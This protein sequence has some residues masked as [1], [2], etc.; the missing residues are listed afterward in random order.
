MTLRVVAVGECMLEL[1]HVND[2]S[3]TLSVAGD[4]FNTAVHLWR[5]LRPRADV[6]YATALGSGWY[7]DFIRNRI[8][9]EGLKP[10]LVETQGAP[11]AYFIRTDDTGE[12]SFS[13]HRSESAA[14]R[15]FDGSGDTTL[16]ESIDGADL[17]HFSAITLQ[18]L[19][20]EA[21]QRFFAVLGAARE[22]G[23]RISFDTNYRPIGWP[24]QHNARRVI[25]EF[26]E[27]ANIVLPSLD[28]ERALG[29]T[30]VGEVVDRY[31]AIGADEV[32]VKDGISPTTLATARGTRTIDVPHANT[33]VDTTGAGDAF[34]AGYLAYRLMGRPP[35][36]AV[37]A[38]HG[39]A[40][41]VVAHP[42][43]IGGRTTHPP[44]CKE[45]HDN[46]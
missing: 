10:V 13:Y 25:D 16:E 39:L 17:V 33:A 14:R 20:A 4:T 36:S 8:Q 41:R 26:A 5:A 34:D 30:S 19:S 9:E 40:A 2:T 44:H 28:D 18:I 43:A 24:S 32:V 1:T 7:A 12:R 27:H 22:A 42:G 21:R 46:R 6:A 3:L 23:T 37:S 45:R 31:R 29:A 15:M 11:G 38:G 35:T